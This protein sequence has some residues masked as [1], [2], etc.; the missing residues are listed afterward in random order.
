MVC[1]R[2]QIHVHQHHSTEQQL[3]QRLDAIFTRLLTMELKLMATMQD[4][5]NEVANEKT[6]IDSVSALI[7]QLQQQIAGLLKGNIPPDVQA[8]ID[9]AFAELQANSAQLAT[10]ISSSTSTGPT[11]AGTT[12][13]GPT[14]APA[15]STPPASPPAA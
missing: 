15:P 2:V 3:T 13:P 8:Q 1:S 11:P 4:I 9:S 7:S 10:A 12:P 14:A 6:E 5:L